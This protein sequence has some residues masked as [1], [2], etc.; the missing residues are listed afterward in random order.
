MPLPVR[1]QPRPIPT[2]SPHVEMVR[3]KSCLDQRPAE[4]PATANVDV[5]QHLT[6]PL[7]PSGTLGG[8][9]NDRGDFSNPELRLNDHHK[10]DHEPPSPHRRLSAPTART[11]A[12]N[13]PVGSSLRRVSLW[14]RIVSLVVA[15]IYV[16][17]PLERL[18]APDILRLPKEFT[19]ASEIAYDIGGAKLTSYTHTRDLVEP[20]GSRHF[21]STV[22]QHSLQYRCRRRRQ[23]ALPYHTNPK[24]AEAY[25]GEK[26]TH[27]VVTVP[28]YFN[29]ARR[30][31]TKDAGTIASLNIL[32]IVNES[33]AE[34]IRH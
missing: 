24:T 31:A 26:V 8:Y 10:S 34:L 17:R 21:V 9:K 28:V 15:D 27:A 32:R 22:N 1:Q 19:T 29:D 7:P 25:L 4:A 23:G 12:S 2:P 6:T 5:Q 16:A 13:P 3:T 14:F 11:A 20:V 30:Q 18:P 33:T